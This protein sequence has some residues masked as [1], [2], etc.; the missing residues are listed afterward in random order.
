MTLDEYA[1]NGKDQFYF[2]EHFYNWY[3]NYL[4]YPTLF[5]RYETL[6]QNLDAL[7]AF[8]RLPEPA[9]REFPAR[10][11]RKTQTN[12]MSAE[13]V[14][15]LRKM[16]QDFCDEIAN[17]SDIVIRQK[18]NLTKSTFLNILLSR[19]LYKHLSVSARVW[20]L[21]NLLSPSGDEA[22]QEARRL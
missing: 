8:L 3:D 13:A 7:F 11:E 6:W 15:G 19:N 10:I 21:S 1:K 18:T 5:V 14:D 2:R 4:L 17:L 20:I 22:E 9:L 16:Y 12:A